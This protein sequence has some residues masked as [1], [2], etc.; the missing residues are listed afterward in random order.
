MSIHIDPLEKKWIIMTSGIV[1]LT[2]VLIIYY[3][4]VENVHPPSNVEVIDS[5]HLH[6]TSGVGGGEFME[7]KLGIHRDVDGALVVTMVAARY[8]FYPQHI[9][10]PINT[11]VKFRIASFDVLHGVLI[12]FSNMNTMIVPGYVSE[13]TT[14]FTRLGDF[15]VICDEYCG[16][17]HAYMYG[18]IK[19]VP[20]DNFKLTAEVH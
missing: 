18:M 3:A 8:G 13:L 10:V 15:P 2:W 9:E 4:A 12:P 19:I 5:A 6:L 11:P 14:S 17:A 20:K 16:L 7:D 1:L